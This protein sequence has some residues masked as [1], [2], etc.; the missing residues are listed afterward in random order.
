[1]VNNKDNNVDGAILWFVMDD[2]S[3]LGFLIYRIM[4]SSFSAKNNYDT[5]L[6][7]KK[8]CY[9]FLNSYLRNLYKLD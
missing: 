6:E 7:I 4:I 1:M 9:I 3:Y 8:T 5:L 2:K